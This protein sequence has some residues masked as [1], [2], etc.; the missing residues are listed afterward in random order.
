M[1]DLRITKTA[2]PRPRVAD[3]NLGFGQVLTDHMLVVDYSEGKGWHDAR[4]VPYGPFSLDPAAVVLHYG[5]AVFDG[6]KAFRNSRKGA[7]LFRPDRHLARLNRS[8]AR[9]CIPPL[10][11]A[12]ALRTLQE[13]VRLDT[14]WIPRSAGC[15]LYVRPTIIAT[16]GALGVHPSK[17]YL[18]FVILS[19]VGAYY[20]EGFN[21]VKIIVEERYVRAAKGGLGAAKTPANYAGSLLAAEEA[22]AKGFTQVLWLDAAEHRYIEEVGTMNILFRNGDELVTPPLEGSILAG[23]TRES[24]LHLARN[25][26]IRVAER[27]I[28][29]D[30]VVEAHAT[31]RLTEVFGSGT[32]AVISPVGELHYKGQRMVINGGAV[33]E[34]TRRF[35]DTIVGIQ[36]GTLD[37]PYG[38]IVPVGA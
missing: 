13:L 18:Y 8:S 3:A 4:I 17:N 32:A 19:P 2:T 24:V 34:W 11:E 35:F 16:E 28:A 15:A 6:L 27:P 14:D 29:I 25:W 10:D 12:F 5:Q 31:G 38:W 33:G 26:K 20:K 36:Y 37:D 21:P 30:E 22:H 1:M 23:V 9:L 7:V